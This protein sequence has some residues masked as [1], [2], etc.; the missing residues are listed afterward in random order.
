MPTPFPP[1]IV[2]LRSDIEKHIGQA[3]LSPSDFQRLIQQIW[4]QQ[5]AILSLSTIKRLWGYVDGNGLPRLS[6]LNTLSQFVGYADWNEYLVALEQ[7][8]GNESAIFQGEGISTAMLQTNDK[9]EVCWQPNRRC[10]FRYLGD[11]QF[12]VEES[13]N[14]K[15]HRGDLFNAATF[16]VGHP[17]YLDNLLCSDGS[18][19]SYVAGK[20]HGL[21]SVNLIKNQ[22]ISISA[23]GC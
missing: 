20:R 19:S 11:N 18:R 16:I 4:N 12:I 7:R 15:L 3:L 6:T 8:G 17:M 14:A 13:I 10:I 23:A 1:E 22:S 9:I 5:H 2:Q 21:T